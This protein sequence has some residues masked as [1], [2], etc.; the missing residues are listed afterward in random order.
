MTKIPTSPIRDDKIFTRR[1]LP[2]S[3]LQS[4]KETEI[5]QVINDKKLNNPLLK[6]FLRATRSR[7]LTSS[8]GKKLRPVKSLFLENIRSENIE[9]TRN[10]TGKKN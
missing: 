7:P 10:L 1:L 3:A 9:K 5:C 2:P 4:W 8:F 6:G